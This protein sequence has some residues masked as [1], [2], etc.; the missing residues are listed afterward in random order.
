MTYKELFAV[1]DLLND[2]RKG[3]KIKIRHDTKVDLASAENY[4]KNIIT[5]INKQK[6]KSK[7]DIMIYQL[8]IEVNK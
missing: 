7:E 3:R 5:D 8:R 2:L 4:F 6:V 1:A